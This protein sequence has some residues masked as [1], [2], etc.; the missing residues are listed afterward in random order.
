MLELSDRPRLGPY[1]LTRE[2]TPTTAFGRG[3]PD[4]AF[5]TPFSVP[6]TP[7]TD[8]TGEIIGESYAARVSKAVQA[9]RFLALHSTDQTSHLAYRF[10]ALKTGRD[11]Q[12]FEEAAKIAAA[13]SHPHALVIQQFGID[14]L[15]HPWVITPFAGDVDGVRPLSKLL[16]EKGGQMSPVEV[17]RALQ[18]LLECVSSAHEGVSAAGAG[19]AG[20]AH[21]T[22]L[23]LWSHGLI[24]IDEVIVDR[25]GS[26][27]VELYGLAAALQP[28]RQ[29]SADAHRDEVRSVI[30]IGY[31]L[32]TGLRAEEPIIPAQRL[33]KRLSSQWSEFF[34][35]GLDPSRG[36]DS[37][38]QALEG[39]PSSTGLKAVVAVSGMRR[40]MSLL[41]A[42]NAGN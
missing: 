18:Q 11:E 31:E 7:L 8:P 9:D 15:G 39:L 1:I 34:D 16:R 6:K 32:I 29:A 21:A 17:E 14:A 5:G 27:L 38:R 12:R 41:R 23:G 36:F 19:D 33:V 26:L 2:L 28:A 22:E 24:S 25:H 42:G 4:L 13:F 3:V 30:E 20:G 10:S 35:H 37:A 40:A